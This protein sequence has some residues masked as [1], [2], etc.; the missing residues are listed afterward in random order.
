ML[1][2]ICWNA[3]NTIIQYVYTCP[4]LSPSICQYSLKFHYCLHKLVQLSVIQYLV[5]YKLVPCEICRRLTSFSA[6]NCIE[7]DQA[8]VFCS[9]FPYYGLFTSVQ[10]DRDIGTHYIDK[11]CSSIITINNRHTNNANSVKYGVLREVYNVWWSYKI[12]ITSSTLRHRHSAA[13]VSFIA[14]CISGL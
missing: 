13:T 6:I 2:L 5:H 4:P 14:L 3:T 10:E 1:T 8:W 9:L 11:S 12:K 7:L